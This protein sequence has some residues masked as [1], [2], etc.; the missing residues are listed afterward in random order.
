ML[1]VVGKETCLL[2]GRL[3]CQ[4][5]L[6]LSIYAFD[7]LYLFFPFSV[8]SHNWHILCC[9]VVLGLLMFNNWLPL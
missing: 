3:V 9:Q 7:Y 8:R 1:D 5:Y 6:L 2:T 4:T